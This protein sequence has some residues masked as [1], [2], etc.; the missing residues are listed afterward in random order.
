MRNR[1]C[2]D[3]PSYY[4]PSP[5]AWLKNDR[6]YPL[7]VY[8]IT[9]LHFHDTL[10]LGVC[11]EGQGVCRVED[12]EYP[13]CEG[14]VQR[15][16]QAEQVVL[17]ESRSAG[18]ARDM[19]RAGAWVIRADAAREDGSLRNSGSEEIPVFVRTGA[20]RRAAGRRDA[21]FGESL[22]IDRGACKSLF[23][24]TEALAFAGAAF[25]PSAARD[26]A[27][28][29]PFGGEFVHRR[30]SHGRSLRAELCAIPKRFSCSNGLFSTAIHTELQD[31]EGAAAFTADRPQ[32]NGYRAGRRI[33]GCFRV[34]SMLSR[35]FRRIAAAAQAE[36]K[37]MKIVYNL[38]RIYRKLIDSG[39][40]EKYTYAQDY[41]SL[42]YSTKS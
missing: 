22:C 39:I 21:A 14:D 4:A 33:S 11:S 23:R 35:A 27:D 31:A 36:G 37:R 2:T 38:F 3:L 16:R 41:S 6:P 12:R 15:G 25:Q 9:S 10:E 28:A 18:R 32:N 29:K 24:F 5:G 26:R 30:S 7:E 8:D 13:F 17:G 1:S 19:G 20:A 40:A 42:L 34:Q